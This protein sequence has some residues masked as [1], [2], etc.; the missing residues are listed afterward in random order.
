MNK[1]IMRKEKGITLIAL[2]VTIVILI[3]L[4]GISINLLIGEDGLIE[5]AKKGSDT[6]SQQQAKEKLELA[7]ADL[8]IDK[9]TDTMY[10]QNTYIDNKLI[11]QGMIVNEN[12]ITVDGWQFE[13]DRSVPKIIASKGKGDGEQG[14]IIIKGQ[15]LIEEISKVNTSGNYEIKLNGIQEDKTQETITY[16]INQIVNNGDLVLDGMQN[17]SG[18][19]LSNNIYEFGN[20]TEDV[21]NETQDAK[22]MVVLKVNGNLTIKSGVTLTACKNTQGYGGPKGMLIYCTGTIKNEGRISMTARGAKAQGENVYLWANTIGTCEYVPA[23][24]A[25]GGESVRAARN[26]KFSGNEGK[27]GEQRQTGGGGSG[28]AN[29]SDADPVAYSG[30]GSNGTSYSGGTG[31][32]GCNINCYSTVRATNGQENGGAGGTGIGYRYDSSWTSRTGGGGAG[33]PGANAE[34]NGVSV[35]N[36]KGENGTGGLL[37]IY[38]NIFNNTGKIE[39]NGSKGGVNND[40]HN[41]GGGSSGGGSINIFYHQNFEQKGQIEAIGGADCGNGSKGGDGTISVGNISTGNYQKVP[42]Q[43]KFEDNEINLQKILN[44]EEVIG[45]NGQKIENMLEYSIK[46]QHEDQLGTK[47]WSSSNENVA[48]VDNNGKVVGINSGNAIITCKTKNAIGMEL[49]DS[50]QVTVKEK[51]YLYFYGNEFTTV[52]GGYTK[53]ARTGRAFSATFNESDVYINCHEAWGGGGILT[54]NKINV[55]DFNYL[56]AEGNLSNY[57]T[58]DSGGRLLAITNS[59]IWGSEWFPNGYIVVNRTER[60]IGTAILSCDISAQS[61]DYYICNGFNQSKGYIYSVWLEK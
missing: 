7:L 1:R 49:T 34:Q 18:A 8:A 42:M 36:A 46:L 15:G 26:Q 38:T 6:Y 25:L 61:G 40:A 55:T 29:S 48:T 17:V 11:Q 50:I 28:T 60:N 16:H 45:N 44:T 51:L 23:T 56:K 33:N 47:Q 10:N 58:T 19:T 27:Q 53:C 57:A 37:I 20:N 52:T 12:I 24:G 43:L 54:S 39:S 31:G 30:A 22:N 2:I 35:E 32:G 5:K 59:L 13:I 14:E 21:A 41:V 4:A 3:I 9:A